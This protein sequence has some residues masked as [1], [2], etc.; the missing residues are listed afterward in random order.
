MINHI[1]S[2]SQ[3][4]SLKQKSLVVLDIDNTVMSF[5]N[6]NNNWWNKTFNDFLYLGKDSALHKTEQIWT[7]NIIN[8]NPELLDREN[9]IKFLDQISNTKSELIFLTARD[10][11]LSGITIKQLEECN[12]I[13]NPSRIFFNKKKGDELKYIVTNVYPRIKNIIFVDDL[14]ENLINVA[15]KFNYPDLFKYNLENQSIVINSS[16]KN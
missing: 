8:D 11:K 3:I 14:T 15:N 1:N 13:V 12:I 4:N 10:K 7:Q 16:L 2:F 9:L 5:S 6:I